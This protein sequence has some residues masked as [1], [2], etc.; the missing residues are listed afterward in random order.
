MVLPGYHFLSLDAG[1]PKHPFFIPKV[2]TLTPFFIP[3]SDMPK[4]LPMKLVAWFSSIFLR[5][6]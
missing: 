1:Q 5:P 3:P 2:R 6:L 4:F